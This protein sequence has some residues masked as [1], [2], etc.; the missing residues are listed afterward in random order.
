MTARELF[1][2]GKL[3]EAIEALGAEMREHPTD[4]QRRSF[5][6]ELLCFAGLWDRADKQLDILAGD[7][8]NKRM[9]ALLYRGAIN[10]A[11]TREEMFETGKF[12]E[13]S[14]GAEPPELTYKVNG[15]G[16]LALEDADIRIG[17]RLEVIAGA[18]YLWIPFAHISTVLIEP[19]QSLRDLIWIP[20]Q[21]RTRT[22][23]AD[24]G[25][26][27]LPVLTPFSWRHADPHVR[28]GRATVWEAGADGTPLPH[29]QKL[30]LTSQEEDVPLLEVRTIEIAPAGA[31]S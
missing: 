15:G 11:R 22:G 6:F 17:P 27:L 9:G 7:D 30:L 3:N 2:A 10:A 25:K 31:A 14:G 24:L 26:V 1:A 28:L 20:A 18:N 13:D 21:V 16:V 19:P 23:G 29:G 5:L 12:P 8:K 4:T